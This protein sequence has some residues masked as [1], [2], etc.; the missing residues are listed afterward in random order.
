MAEFAHILFDIEAFP[1]RESGN[2]VS[3]SESELGIQ[4]QTLSQRAVDLHGGSQWSSAVSGSGQTFKVPQRRHDLHYYLQNPG[5]AATT[6]CSQSGQTPQV[7]QNYPA[8]DAQGGPSR[9]RIETLAAGYPQENEHQQRC[10]LNHLTISRAPSRQHSGMLPHDTSLGPRTRFVEDATDLE[11]SLFTGLDANPSEYS[12]GL[13]I[14]KD[15]GSLNRFFPNSLPSP[16]A[17]RR[18]E[19]YEEPT[20]LLHQQLAPHENSAAAGDPHAQVVSDSNTVRNPKVGSAAG[21]EAAITRRK[22]HARYTCDV[23]GCTSRGFTTKQ[24]LKSE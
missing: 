22:G 4:A 23:K 18:D 24:N 2:Q 8:F 14:P 6:P 13:P 16:P 5:P 11:L 17:V 12:K 19:P 9:S 3:P 20:S 10:H 15:H 1:R 21:T 7:P